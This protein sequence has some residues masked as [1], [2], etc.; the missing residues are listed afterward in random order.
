MFISDRPVFQQGDKRI[1]TVFRNT[2]RLQSRKLALLREMEKFETWK[3]S[4][5]TEKS[6]RGA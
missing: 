5:E 6:C 3:E 4:E 2:I 1:A